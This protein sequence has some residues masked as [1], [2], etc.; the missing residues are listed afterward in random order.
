[1]DMAEQCITKDVEE[2]LL[3]LLRAEIERWGERKR[4]GIKTKKKIE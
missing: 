1:M 3:L 2:L 4:I